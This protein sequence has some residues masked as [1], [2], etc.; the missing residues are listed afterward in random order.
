LAISWQT[1]HLNAELAIRPSSVS[2][3]DSTAAFVSIINRFISSMS[4]LSWLLLSAF[5]F[6]LSTCSSRIAKTFQN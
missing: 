5:R 3:F 4:L 6:L 1:K 2:L